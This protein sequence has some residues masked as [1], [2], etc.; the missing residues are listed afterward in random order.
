MQCATRR[1]KPRD[2]AA[3]GKWRTAMLASIAGIALAALVLPVGINSTGLVVD[4]AIAANDDDGAGANGMALENATGQQKQDLVDPEDVDNGDAESALSESGDSAEQPQIKPSAEGEAANT[5]VIK[6][7]A[8][9]AGEAEL[10][11]EE[12][13]E[14]IRSG[15]GTW[16]TADGPGT[17]V[18][19]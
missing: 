19:Q 5:N 15:W 10:T 2:G 13:I 4:Q 17:V 18:A 16:R 8:G 3:T 1:N 7:I 9:L 12:E 6:E 14:A 11:E